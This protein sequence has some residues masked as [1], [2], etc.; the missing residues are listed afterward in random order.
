MK[1]FTELTNLEKIIALG[2]FSLAALAITDVSSKYLGR[3]IDKKMLNSF[4]DDVF[5][6][7]V[8]FYELLEADKS[9]NQDEI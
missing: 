8:T 2:G 5:L 7:A 1:K 6:E 9:G 4:F 3:P